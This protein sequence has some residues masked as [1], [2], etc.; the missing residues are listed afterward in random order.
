MCYGCYIDIIFE[1][2]AWYV[3]LIK[4]VGNEAID[5]YVKEPFR[6]FSGIAEG[7]REWHEAE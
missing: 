3:L 5:V 4:R 2:K 6:S 1:I 7:N